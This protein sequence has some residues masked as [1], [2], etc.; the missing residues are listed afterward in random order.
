MRTQGRG[1]WIR[2]AVKIGAIAAVVVLVLLVRVVTSSQAE[3]TQAGRMRAAGEVEA[4][5][6]HYR[7]AAR[8]YAPGNPY[9]ADALAGLGEIGREAEQAGDTELAL[10]AWR[11]VRAAILSTRSF[12]TPH[13]DRL[14]AANARI[15]ALMASLPPPPIDAGKST[16]ELRREHLDLLTRST[17]P[18]VGWTL[19][20]LLGFVAWVGGTFA[21]VTRAVDDEDRLVA[22]KARRWGTVIIIGFGLFVLGLALA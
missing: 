13:A 14:E 1:R 11:A 17:R 2:I 19:V 20:L 8:W 21:F 3:L 9:S 10:S 4:A 15:A 7:R 16:E 18:H 22:G 6:V 5:V 12:Y